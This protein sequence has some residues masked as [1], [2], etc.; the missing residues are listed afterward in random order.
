MK[1]YFTS[2]MLG[3]FIALSAQDIK[4][5]FGDYFGVQIQDGKDMKVAMTDD[6][7]T[8]LFSVVPKNGIGFG[9]IIAR[10]FDQKGN[11]MDT[12]IKDYKSPKIGTILNYLGSKEIDENRF[13]VYTEEVVAKEKTKEVFQHVFNRKS[14]DFSTTSIAKYDIESNIKS[15]SSFVKFS[16]NN[17]Y[18]AIINDRFANKKTPNIID[19]LVI[20]LRTLN[21]VW[22]KEI[23]LD[24][25]FVEGE[26]ALTNSANILVFRNP[27]G[28]ATDHQLIM[29][30]DNDVKKIPLEDK[31]IMNN[32]YPIS[33][34]DQDY[35]ISFGY[36]RV[37]RINQGEFNYM[38]LTDLR[39]GKTVKSRTELFSTNLDINQVL[40]R[41]VSVKDKQLAIFA[42]I[43]TKKTP[44]STG[45]NM[46]PES[47][48]SYGPAYLIKVDATG[49]LANMIKLGSKYNND[50]M[51]IFDYDSNIFVGLKGP[52]EQID[53]F[54]FD[55]N[56]FSDVVKAIEVP[57]SSKDQSRGY[58]VPNLTYFVPN[59][60]K[61]IN[62]RRSSTNMSIRNTYN[63]IK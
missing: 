10:K 2:A 18:V 3:V 62:F 16:E 9:Q 55:Y 58:D 53:L 49:N 27:A 61:L 63:L 42:E 26:F 22:Q 4:L 6:Y 37:T 19:N 59:S 54:K 8:Y 47:I 39:D 14:N 57:Y 11:L 32:L 60:N 24:N 44:A 20:D 43:E 48:Y 38:T 40:V 51:A 46:F 25:D 45:T 31:F 30:S 35:L 17:K 41:K 21:K 28:W 13:V 56:T 1:K 29:Y 15:G 50:K 12:V 5:S 33:I 23:T 7:A 34:N 36:F 52:N